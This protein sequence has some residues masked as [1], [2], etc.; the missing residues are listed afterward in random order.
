MSAVC[1]S[2]AARKTPK[3]AGGWASRSTSPFS[4]TIWSRASRNVAASRS[5][6]AAVVL[7]SAASVGEPAFE[8][9]DVVRM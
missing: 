8:H 3:L 4:E 2:W 1:S 7:A 6:L 5:L 9:G